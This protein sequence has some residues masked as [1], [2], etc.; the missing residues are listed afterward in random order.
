MTMTPQQWQRVKS[1]VMEAFELEPI[2]REEFIARACDDTRTRREIHALLDADAHGQLAPPEAPFLIPA[3]PDSNASMLVGRRVGR[4]RVTRLIGMGGM[5][6][7]YEATRDDLVR[8]VALKVMRA[9]L[10]SSAACARFQREANLLSRLDHPGIAR[11][12][13]SGM[14]ESELGPIPYF[15]MEFVPHSAPITEFARA[16]N[17]TIRERVVVFAD[18]CNAVHHGHQRGIIHRDLK[19]SNILVAASSGPSHGVRH[20]DS[21]DSLSDSPTVKVIDFGIA[22]STDADLT[23]ASFESAPHALAGTL[24]YMSPE[25]CAFDPAD[26]DIR[27]DVYSLGVVLHE[28]LVGRP[29]YVVSEKALPEAIRIIQET[30]VTSP[31]SVE[32]KL[33]NDL[34]IIIQ[35]CLAKEREQRYASASELGDDLRR[36]LGNLPITARP[37]SRVYAMRLFARRN[38]SL[39]LSACVISATVLI[40]LFLTVFAWRRAIAERDRARHAETVAVE[41]E[42]RAM[43]VSD[44]LQGVLRSTSAPVLLSRFKDADIS[45]I[46]ASGNSMIPSLVSASRAESVRDV[47]ERARQSLRVGTALDPFLAAELRLLTLQLLITQTGTS[48]QNAELARTGPE[49]IRQAAGVLG[50]THPT[51]LSA[52]LTLSAAM[53]GTDEAAQIVEEAYLAAKNTLGTSDPRTLELGRQWVSLL[54]RPELR[55]RRREIARELT[56]DAIISHGENSRIALAC[57]LQEASVAAQDNKAAKAAEA[58]RAVLSRF[59]HPVDPSEDLVRSALELSTADIPRIPASR[60]DLTRIAVVQEQVLRGVQSRFQ[61]DARASFDSASALTGTLVQLGEFTRAADLTR[62]IAE[63]S[64]ASFGPTFHVTTKCQSRVARLLVWGGGSLDEALQ[65]AQAAV[66]NSVAGSGSP[67][68]DYEVFDQAT[69]LDVRRARGDPAAALQGI[70]TLLEGYRHASGGHLSWFGTYLHSIAA[71]S[72]D[73]LQRTDEA[74]QHWIAALDEAVANNAPTNTLYILTMRGAASFFQRHGPVPLAEKA[75]RLLS[76]CYVGPQTE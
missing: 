37:A 21:S 17:L 69:L 64:A 36:W 49:E 47:V 20:L 41:Q 3:L 19:P 2:A 48:A 51:V 25:Q 54:I 46:A 16:S 27:S 33:G 29:P 10:I 35:K 61:D 50:P 6:A 60:D 14:H 38:R 12:Y 70:E 76:E 34:S 32:P 68:G 66:T 24:M 62:Q 57:I 11:I 13:D 30:R 40:A 15:A 59:P 71:R 42:M 65:L 72:L 18:V 23:L 63:K 58:A 75:T 45:P 73:T 53:A 1:I 4:Y 28:L 8:P 22:R 56:R 55:E 44:F 39:F 43:A 52:A 26:I 9:G 7:V 5:G 74:R 67:L 31:S